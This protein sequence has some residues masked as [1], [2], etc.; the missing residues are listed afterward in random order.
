[1]FSPRGDESEVTR[2]E[3]LFL[4]CNTELT[5]SCVKGEGEGEMI[6]ISMRRAEGEYLKIGISGRRV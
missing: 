2:G 4:F 5:F 3:R 1:M 6:V